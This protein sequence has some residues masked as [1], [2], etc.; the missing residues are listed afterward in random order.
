MKRLTFFVIALCFAV[1]AALMTRQ[2]WKPIINAI[3]Q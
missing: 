2:A 1:L 3:L